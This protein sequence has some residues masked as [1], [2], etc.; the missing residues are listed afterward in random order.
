[1]FTQKLQTSDE[2][3]TNYHCVVTCM[4]S[5]IRLSAQPTEGNRTAD[6]SVV[7]PETYR[8]T[9]RGA[10][11]VQYTSSSFDLSYPADPTVMGNQLEFTML[12]K[13][14][15]TL[16]LYA[17]V[18]MLTGNLAEVTGSE[19]I[20]SYL[21]KSL[22]AHNA[23]SRGRDGKFL[24]IFT[25][26]VFENDACN[27][28]SINRTGICFSSSECISRG[29]RAEGICA[30]GYG[31]CCLFE[32]TCDGNSFNNGTYFQNPNY[33]GGYNEAR[34]CQAF[35]RK[36]HFNVCQFRLDFISFDI[37]QPTNGVCNSDRLVI[38]GQS[39][40]SVVPP[41]CG[42]NTGQHLYIEVAGTEG[43][44]QLN[45]ITQGSRTRSF[46]I[47]ITQIGCQSRDRDTTN[48]P[49]T[50]RFVTNSEFISRG[51]LINYRQNP[52]TSGR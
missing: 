50:A 11:G 48:G 10:I 22:N 18:S 32:V 44:I 7:N 37:S 31:V 9:S 6:F 13:L 25:L 20:D 21:N 41:I 24:S 49:F 36:V 30:G 19:N 51:F 1:M 15:I 46:D 27:T 47:R 17:I 16:T 3:S 28:S 43:P 45:V 52:C 12:S 8:C 42:L 29:G 39:Q 33:P 2:K 26:A 35:I 14:C 4:Q 40:N 5:H 23:S 34:T 38:S